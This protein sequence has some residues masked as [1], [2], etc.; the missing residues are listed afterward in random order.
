M[1]K[2]HMT[3]K[4]SVMIFFKMCHT[5]QR[6]SVKAR[7]NKANRVIPFKRAGWRNTIG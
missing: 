3:V 1:L 2:V 5:D 4:L 7:R 6:V